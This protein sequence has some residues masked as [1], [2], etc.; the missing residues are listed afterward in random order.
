MTTD[1]GQWDKIAPTSLRATMLNFYT[2]VTPALN[3][4]NLIK[5]LMFFELES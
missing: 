3:F 2:L 1:L 4:Q 5:T